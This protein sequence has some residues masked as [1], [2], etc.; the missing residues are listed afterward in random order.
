MYGDTVEWS[1]NWFFQQVDG[2]C[3]PSSAAQMIAQYT[4]VVIDNPDNSSTGPSDSDS[5]RTAT[6][7]RA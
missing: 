7:H 1:V 5:C 4:G 6:P 3:G 2:Y